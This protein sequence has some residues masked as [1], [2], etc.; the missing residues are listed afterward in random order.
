MDQ[1]GYQTSYK[2]EMLINQTCPSHVHNGWSQIL[3]STS[4]NKRRDTF[5]RLVWTEGQRAVVQEWSNP[6]ECK[7]AWICWSV[8][9]RGI[10]SHAREPPTV[11]QCSFAIAYWAP[12]ASSRPHFNI[13]ECQ[14]LTIRHYHSASRFFAAH[15]ESPTAA[16]LLCED[17]VG[18]VVKRSGT[19]EEAASLQTIM[20]SSRNYYWIKALVIGSWML[21]KVFFYLKVLQ[22]R[23]NL[24]LFQLRICIEFVTSS[25][26]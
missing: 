14:L 8:W 4:R 17:P 23:L 25:G 12:P 6:I 18:A 5:L 1:K 19:K 20:P 21:R 2:I 16:P 7:K 22:L 26:R 9:A 13:N 10:G 24:H 3:Q 11:Q 15:C